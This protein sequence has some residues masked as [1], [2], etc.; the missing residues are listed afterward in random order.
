MARDLRVEHGFLDKLKV[1]F[2]N[3]SVIVL[4]MGKVGTLTVCNSLEQAGFG[5][6]HPH[7]LFF[8]RPGVHFVDIALTRRQRL[9][10]AYKT[11]TKRIK[12]ALWHFCSGEVL[13]ISGVRDPFS[14]AISAYFEQ[15]HYFGGI[16]DEWGYD[17]IKADFERRALFN[18]T[19][20]WFDAEIKRFSGIDVLASDFDPALGYKVFGNRKVRLFVYRMEKLNEL[21]PQIADFLG[22]EKFEILKTNDTSDS[23][24]ACKYMDFAKQ[25]KYDA[26][27]VKRLIETRYVQTF[28]TANEI[29]A[30]QSR[31][32]EAAD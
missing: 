32:V 11:F 29:L 27:L 17:D 5:N 7:S 20:K 10:Y 3:N 16:P 8:T 14:R 12:V 26:K 24:N 6:V 4:T 31:W 1:W 13:I 25:Y 2:S 19:T 23:H 28:F 22:I 15:S 9:W 30:L 21:G 18:S